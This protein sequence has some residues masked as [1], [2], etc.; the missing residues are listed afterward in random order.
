[1]L[2]KRKNS[3]ILFLVLLSICIV[4]VLCSVNDSFY[5][6]ETIDSN[7][8]VSEDENV[9]GTPDTPNLFTT[10]SI[11][12]DGG[13]GYVIA[14]AKNDFTLFS[15]TVYVIVQLFSS[16]TYQENYQNMTMVASDYTLDLDM[17]D[18]IS[19]S[20]STNG[21]QKYWLA[22]IRYK[23]N[24]GSWKEKDTGPVLCDANGDFL[25]LI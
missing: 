5:F 2:L 23:V 6:A 19:V 17:G 8:Y 20:S 25:G 4:F 11:S 12:I 18:T 13:N 10:L 3:L 1:M 22:R 16:Y 9:L 14:T 7:E 21:E 24:N 15:S